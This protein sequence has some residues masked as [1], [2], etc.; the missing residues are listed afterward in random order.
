PDNLALQFVVAE[1]A[2]QRGDHSIAR[3]ILER[4]TSIDGDAFF[5]PGLAY[6]KGLFG[7]LS[8]ELLA[9]CHFRSGQFEAAARVYRLAAETAPA[10]AACELKARLAEAR[11]AA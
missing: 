8:A 10:S 9:L 1:M 6:D 5:E 4:L 11:A 3:P 2:V 7:H